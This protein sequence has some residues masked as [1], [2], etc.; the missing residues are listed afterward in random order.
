VIWVHAL[1]N[2]SIPVVTMIGLEFAG[3][4]GG[5]LIIETIYA[6]PG[7]GRLVINAVLQRDFP[8]VQGVVLISAATFVI[9][10]LI[11]DLF[12]SVLDPRIT[13]K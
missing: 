5:A 11:V 7:I 9:V 13:Y 2:A 4:L 10:N 6:W 3:L 12:Y 1:K 8:I